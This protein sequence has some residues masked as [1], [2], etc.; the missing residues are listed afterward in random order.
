MSLPA[1]FSEPYFRRYE[2]TIAQIVDA[3]P[4]P[5]DFQIAGSVTTFACRLRDAMKSLTE[6]KWP[7]T[8][9]NMDVFNEIHPSPKDK[10]FVVQELPNGIVR[11][12]DSNLL[13]SKDSIKVAVNNSTSKPS[14][15]PV[16]LLDLNLFQIKTVCL[17]AH[18]RLL[19]TSILVSL[20]DEEATDLNNSFDIL[21]EKQSEGKYLLT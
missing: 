3:W 10:K 5:V 14:N 21:L 13:I 17:L 1:R 2:Q 12:C 18:H 9:V 15:P 7:T 6:N 8:M 19:N 16:E 11:V 4:Q 20:A